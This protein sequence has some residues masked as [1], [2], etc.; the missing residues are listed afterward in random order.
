MGICCM[1]YWILHRRDTASSNWYTASP[2]ALTCA[3]PR[4]SVEARLAGSTDSLSL[5]SAMR[6]SLARALANPHVHYGRPAHSQRK[7][8]PCSLVHSAV[9]L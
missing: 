9:K 6:I 7:Q 3:V 2:R 1:G 4:G 8:P 5:Q